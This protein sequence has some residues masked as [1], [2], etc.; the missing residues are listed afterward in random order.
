MNYT[1]KNSSL[2]RVPETLPQD[3]TRVSR[4]LR[5]VAEDD[6][7]YAAAGAEMNPSLLSERQSAHTLLSSP[8]HAGV[9]L[10]ANVYSVAGWPDGYQS[11]VVD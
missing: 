10:A 11:E 2:T 9:L 3:S 4:R 5:D 7:V 8:S 6:G 1:P